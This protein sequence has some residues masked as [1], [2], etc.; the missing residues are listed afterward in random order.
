ML[1][2]AEWLF[3]LVVFLANVIQA[4]TGFAGTVLAMPFSMLLIGTDQAKAVL[5]VLTMLS[6]AVIAFQGRRHIRW[7]ELGRIVLFM[8]VGMAV[9]MA[10]YALAPLDVLKRVYGVVIVVIAVWNLVSRR[11]AELSRG[12]LTAILL[13]SG[14]IHGMFVSGGALLVV[15]AAQTL[16]DK[17]EFRSTMAAVWVPLNAV[18][19]IQLAWSGGVD[20]QTAALSAIALIPL[21]AA[22]AV[23]GWIGGRISQRS[24]MTLTYLLL[25]ISGLSIVL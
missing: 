11:H 17:D 9:G 2:L 24:F 8:A 19:L 14:V 5:A 4:I 21:A 20:Q 23:G 15:Y 22:V 3:L 13:A 1:T 18:L 16:P 12:A 10:V 25:A 7:R 6:C